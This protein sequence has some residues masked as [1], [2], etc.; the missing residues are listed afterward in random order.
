MTTPGFLSLIVSLPRMDDAEACFILSNRFEVDRIAAVRLHWTV[1]PPCDGF[2]SDH[3]SKRERVK[4][5]MHKHNTQT[6]V[7]S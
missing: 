7:W 3:N 5:A 1:K 2:M 4:Q 6:V